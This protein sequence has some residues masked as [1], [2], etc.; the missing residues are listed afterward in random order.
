M[1]W[2]RKKT[3]YSIQKSF[4]ILIRCKWVFATVVKLNAFLSDF[5]ALIDCTEKA[6]FELP[7]STV[8]AIYYQL[9]CI[10]MQIALIFTWKIITKT[11]LLK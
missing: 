1:E 2:W 3:L 11:R 7:F 8:S 10:I 4:N 6:V 9:S 5:K